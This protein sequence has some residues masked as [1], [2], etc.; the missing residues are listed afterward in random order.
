MKGKDN[1]T[2]S[3]RTFTWIGILWVFA[4]FAVTCLFISSPAN[5]GGD[6]A[7]ALVTPSG[8]LKPL[9]SPEV[10]GRDNLYEKIDGQAELYLSSG[11]VSMRSQWFGEAEVPDPMVEV[12]VYD[13]GDGLNA[14]SVYSMQRREGGKKVDLVQFAYGTENALYFVHGRYYVEMIASTDS[15]ETFSE[16]VKLAEDFVRDTPV[17]AA[18]IEGLDLFPKENLDQDSVSMIAKNAF[19]FDLLDRVFTAAYTLG[20]DKVTAFVSRRKTPRE[21]KRLG[22]GLHEFFLSFGGKD[23]E[24]DVEI[25]GA[26][27][28]QI[29]GRFEIIFC[30]DSYLA[31]VHEAPTKREA[32]ELAER[33]AKRLRQ[34]M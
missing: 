27:L 4:L 30:V 24:P 21:A 9:G 13:M 19:G 32:E 6:H 17:N 31:G 18:W 23:L 33:L 25:E 15:G 10:F 14:F 34:R 22:S 11:L 20:K 26:K 8:G 5:P 28:V 16:M 7:P 2:K 12:N 29:M 1:E 3:P